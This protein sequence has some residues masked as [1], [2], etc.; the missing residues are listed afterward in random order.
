MPRKVNFSSSAGMPWGHSPGVNQDD[1]R[2]ANLAG[3]HTSDGLGFC[4]R[5][6]ARRSESLPV[7]VKGASQGTGVKNSKSWSD[8]WSTP[9]CQQMV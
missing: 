6:N 7:Q 1:E 2:L 9:Q 8:E 5:A 4:A 3:G